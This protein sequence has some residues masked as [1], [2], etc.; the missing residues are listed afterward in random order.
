V[1]VAALIER[2]ED[3]AVVLWPPRFLQRYTLAPMLRRARA[4]GKAPN[5]APVGS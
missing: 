5:G 4:R 2:Y 3:V 1:K